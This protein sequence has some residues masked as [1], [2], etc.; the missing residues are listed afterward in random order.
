M[1][2]ALRVNKKPGVTHTFLVRQVL[3]EGRLT[4]KSNFFS[5]L[6]EDLLK[7]GFGRASLVE[8][9]DHAIQGTELLGFPGFLLRY[10][11]AEHVQGLRLCAAFLVFIHTEYHGLAEVIQYLHLKLNLVES[12]FRV[13]KVHPLEVLGHP[14][15]TMLAEHNDEVAVAEH[16]LAM[17]LPLLGECPKDLF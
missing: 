16:H 7:L 1:R 5:I 8:G 4:L 10:L 17:V 9:E 11:P 6:G 15:I 13:L 14:T 12:L 2:P 3:T